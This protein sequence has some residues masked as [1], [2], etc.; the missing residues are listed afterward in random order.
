MFILV[1]LSSLRYDF[2]RFI[3]RNEG[4]MLS[5]AISEVNELLVNQ[6][7]F[8]QI[9]AWV[10]LIVVVVFAFYLLLSLLLA[11]GMYFY[12]RL[13]D[14]NKSNPISREELLIGE[15]TE[16][17]QGSS[18]GEVMSIDNRDA[19]SSYP[20]KLYRETEQQRNVSLPKGTKVLIVGFD[21]QGIALV[22]ERNSI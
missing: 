21:D 5:R 10:I 22:V 11:P 6:S 4:T 1:C 16:K 20:A 18:V 8:V 12:N 15:L 3:E 13:T 19:R 14:R 17:I 2:T 9:F 7:V